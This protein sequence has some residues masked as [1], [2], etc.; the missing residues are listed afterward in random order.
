MEDRE[1][2]NSNRNS[3]REKWT[4]SRAKWRRMGRIKFIWTSIKN[5]RVRKKGDSFFVIPSL[6]KREKNGEDSSTMNMNGTNYIKAR[7]Q[8]KK[9]RKRQKKL[10]GKY[11]AMDYTKFKIQP[12]FFLNPLK[13]THKDKSII[14]VRYP[15]RQGWRIIEQGQPK[16]L[17]YQA[18]GFHS[19]VK[20]S[21]ILF[22]K[23]ILFSR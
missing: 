23:E 9:N 15:Q 22:S 3:W 4:N 21:K 5:E 17:K 10:L 11:K 13:Q 20:N 16:R 18:L 2:F 12:I 19:D 7:G 14:R 1:D 8:P 6:I